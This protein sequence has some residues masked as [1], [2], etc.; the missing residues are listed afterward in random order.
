[1]LMMLTMLTCMLILCLLGLLAY[2]LAYV[3]MAY[4]LRLTGLTYTRAGIPAGKP[5]AGVSFL[6]ACFPQLGSFF[7]CWFVVKPQSR[8]QGL[9]RTGDLDL[10]PA[11][12][13][14]SVAV[15][16]F[17]FCRSIPGTLRTRH[18]GLVSVI[19]GATTEGVAVHRES[20]VW[21]NW[22]INNRCACCNFGMS[23]VF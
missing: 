6:G 3:S 12:G 5:L 10:T 22:Q 2:G 14:R 18:S 19:C 17:P 15:F 23:L 16:P 1:M 20:D 11:R 8:R 13:S 21:N 4:G 7:C 9:G